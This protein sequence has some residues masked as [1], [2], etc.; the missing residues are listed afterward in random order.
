MRHANQP[1]LKAGGT[2][3]GQNRF[4]VEARHAVVRDDRATAAEFQFGGKTGPREERSPDPTKM[5]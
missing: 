5:G 3:R 1:R 2:E 4:G